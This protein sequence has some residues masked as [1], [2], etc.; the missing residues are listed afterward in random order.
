MVYNKVS[1]L[2]TYGDDNMACYS[3]KL[4]K[5]VRWFYRFYDNGVPYTSQCK[6]LSKSEAKKAEREHIQELEKKTLQ[7]EG[8][9][10]ELMLSPLIDER[11]EHLKSRKSAMYYKSTKHYLEMFLKHFGNSSI[12]EI[13]KHQINKFLQ[14]TS[15]NLKENGHSNYPVNSML[16]AI[17]ALFNFVIDYYGIEMVNPCK[18]IRMYPIDKKLK[19]IPS[20]SEINAVLDICDKEQKFLILFAMQTG[21]R[22]GEALRFTKKDIHDGYIVL[23]TRKSVNS[24]LTPRKIPTPE[25]LLNWKASDELPFKRWKTAP[26]FIKCK[27]RALKLKNWG[28]HCLRH[29][30]A[31]LLSK[32]NKPIFEIMM[33]L[34]H[35]NLETTQKYLQLLS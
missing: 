28:W 27:Q 23:Y 13:K 9:G 14:K 1:T 11:L 33:L 34:G 15:H 6:Y 29:R 20:D 5:G 10:D 19:Y 32:Q 26:E 2:K 7:F 12:K 22:I 21:A 17:K 16:K 25:C 24:N 30:Y 31:S 4:A 8:K 18:G 35:S 3:R